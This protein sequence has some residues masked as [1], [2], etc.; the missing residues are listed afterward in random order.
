MSLRTRLLL[1]FVLLLVPVLGGSYVVMVRGARRGLR[2]SAI[3]KANAMAEL[4]AAGSEFAGKLPERA[5]KLLG[6]QM[7]A[8]AR[9]AA[10]LVAVAESGEKLSQQEIRDRLKD[11]ADK[12]VLDEF[13]ITDD[14]GRA[15]LRNHEEIDFTF[16]AEPGEKKQSHEFWHLLEVEDGKF[17]QKAM[18]REYDGKIYKY[19]AVSGVDRPRIVQ[20]GLEAESLDAL[21]EGL[22]DEDMGEAVTGSA[23]ILRFQVIGP[24][25]KSVFDARADDYRS[26]PHGIDAKTLAMARRRSGERNRADV[27]LSGRYHMAAVPFEGDDGPWDLVLSLDAGQSREFVRKARIYLGTAAIGL[28]LLSGFLALRFSRRIAEPVRRLAEEAEEIGQGNL[29]RS[30]DVQGPSEVGMLARAFNNMVSSLNAHI[31]QLRRTTAEKQKLETEMQTAADVQTALLSPSLPELAGLQV[32]ACTFPARIVGG[33]FY[34]VLRMPDGTLGFALGDASGKGL[35]AALVAAECLSIFRTLSVEHAEVGSVLQRANR[36]LL[37]TA[38]SRGLF[39]TAFCGRFDPASG[40]LRFTNAGHTQPIL[41]RADGTT[42][43]V[44]AAST[45]PLG[46]TERFESVE[47]TSDLQPG[48]TLVIYSDGVPDARNG[49]GEFFTLER[50]RECVG[51]CAGFSADELVERIIACVEEFRNGTERSDDMTLVVL[52]RD[53]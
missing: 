38:A 52:R 35:P 24:D 49:A 36:V 9:L 45:F 43:Y 2:Q 46:V 7:I 4:L 16:R 41:F 42:E 11:V 33:D 26:D 27:R 22:T 34:E 12:T 48:E 17:I 37:E 13:W 6:E 28:V 31:E 14:R 3:D 1:A 51:G 29:D 47:G 44:R 39:V 10:H 21:M 32:C 23:G 5:E 40:R 20:V 8:Q 19:A 53:G 18:P 30:I 15:Y 50:L 25:G